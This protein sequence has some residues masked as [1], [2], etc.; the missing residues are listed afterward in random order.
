MDV[1]S[2]GKRHEP[3]LLCLDG[4]YETWRHYPVWN[5]KNQAARSLETERP[6]Q[7]GRKRSEE[8]RVG[9]STRADT[10]SVVQVLRATESHAARRAHALRWPPT[11]PAYLFCR[12][13]CLLKNATM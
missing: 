10:A 9:L 7:V 8:R 6:G 1:R 5:K 3:H 2:Y 4:G 13:R 11:S 12:P